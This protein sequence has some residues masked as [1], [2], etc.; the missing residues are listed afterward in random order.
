MPSKLSGAIGGG[1]TVFAFAVLHDLWISD[2]WFNIV[3]MIL[4]GALCGWSIAWSYQQTTTEHSWQR[5]F[6]FN[7]VCALLLVGLGAASFV[8]LEPRFTMAEV[9]NADDALGQLLPPAMPLIIGGTLVG[10]VVLWAGFGRRRA[11]L[12]P[13][14]VSQAL[15]MFLVGHNL[16]ILGL[17]DIPTDQLYRVVEFVGVTVFLAGMYALTV[18]LLELILSRPRTQTASSGI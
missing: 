9:M 16:A 6:G 10:A 17:V 15:L 3:P 13:M 7:A 18:L 2:I 12:L 5:W 8:L 11:G 4:S 14:L 1:L